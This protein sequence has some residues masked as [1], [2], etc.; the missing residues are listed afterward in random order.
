MKQIKPMIIAVVLVCVL[1]LVGSVTAYPETTNT[2][3]VR[4]DS[5]SVRLVRHGTGADGDLLL[6]DAGYDLYTES[7]EKL[8]ETP[9]YTDVTGTIA[10]DGLPRG[11]YTLR[12]VEPP[13]GYRPTEARAFTIDPTRGG[14]GAVRLDVVG[15][16]MT[17]DF[18]LCLRTE[19]GDPIA[20]TLFYLYDL[21]KKEPEIAAKAESDA[22]GYIHLTAAGDGPFRLVEICPASGRPS[23]YGDALT[24]TTVP[25]VTY[26][27]A[28]GRV[29]TPGEDGAVS[30]TRGEKTADACDLVVSAVNQNDA[31]TPV[32]GATFTLSRMDGGE[33]Q[34]IHANLQTNKYGLLYIRGLQ[35][36]AY[37]LTETRPAPDHRA[38]EVYHDFDL[39][40]TAFF[41][42]RHIPAGRITI[43]E[44]ALGSPERRLAG[45][46]YTLYYDVDPEDAEGRDTRLEAVAE[47]VTDAD[48]RLSFDGL[49]PGLYHLAQS[50][51]PAG[52]RQIQ[53]PEIMGRVAVGHTADGD[54]HE[55][56]HPEEVF[57]EIQAIPADTKEPP[58]ENTA[59]VQIEPIS[60]TLPGVGWQSPWHSPLLRTL[61]WIHP[62]DRLT[63]VIAVVLVMVLAQCLYLW[64][65][66][67]RNG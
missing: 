43:E 20:D 6:A 3:R 51:A 40:S 10:I 18:D 17:R 60:G 44:T 56:V 1:T 53:A 48:G 12:E 59:G 63:L 13:H 49:K 15:D 65:R 67:K 38:L 2:N 37:R 62:F 19:T 22:D 58:A 45:A 28:D 64:R 24:I 16:P 35:P 47:G 29:R 31:D 27:G 66:R 61:L 55:H 52:Y 34:E 21:G 4:S 26:T 54:G 8:T 39:N 7:G 50:K 41:E 23:G 46:A 30:I 5:G 9:Y 33:G 11:A 32:A 42:T 57:P 14:G 25:S 36:G